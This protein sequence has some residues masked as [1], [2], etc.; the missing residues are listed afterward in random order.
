MS[1]G[2]P[3]TLWWVLIS[4]LSPP[5]DSTMSGYSVPCTRKRGA[6]DA[7]ES[8][9]ASSNTRMNV[10][11][12]ILRLRSGSTTSSSAPR[13]RSAAFTCTRSIVELLAERLL[14]LLGLALAQQPGVD[15]HARE[16]VA[17][18]LVHERGGDRGVDPAGQ[19]ADHPLGADLGPDLGDRLLDDRD[20]G[21]RGPAPG[22]V[23]EERLEHLLAALGVHHLGVELHAVDRAV[24]IAERGDRASR[25]SRRA[26]RSPG[27]AAGDRVEVA[28]PHDLLERL[29]VEQRAGRG[30]AQVGAA[31]L[32]APGLGDLA[33][34]LH[35][36]AAAR[37]NRCRASARRRS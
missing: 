24:G 3:P 31:V 19:P 29:L 8:R 9:A 16:L 5:P 22:D 15:E 2:R 11:P 26:P 25:R 13:N 33:A 10:S 28:H 37:R 36:R 4:A 21:P 12:M 32:A 1:S 23:V 34:E 20:V 7:R 27:G 6:S 35:G 30:D 18:G 17:D 14:D